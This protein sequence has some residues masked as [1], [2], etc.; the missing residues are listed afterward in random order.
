M[1]S[2]M[3][4]YYVLALL[5]FVGILAALSNQVLSDASAAPVTD[6]AVLY[7]QGGNTTN[8]MGRNLNLPSNM[9]QLTV[10][11][12]EPDL[13]ARG[14]GANIEHVGLQGSVH[15]AAVYT[16]KNFQGD[17]ETVNS[18]RSELWSPSNTVGTNI[19]SIRLNATCVGPTNDVPVV[20]D[21]TS[22]ADS[23]ANARCPSGYTRRNQDLNEGARGKYTYVCVQF[24]P[25][26]S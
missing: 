8:I 6:G 10:T 17:C 12:D 18:Y 25:R 9:P 24:G 1:N 3:R 7:K 26:S 21:V 11:K 5:S 13:A 22:V 23:S 14:F 16:Q 19:Q 2:R 15:A 4:N 20:T